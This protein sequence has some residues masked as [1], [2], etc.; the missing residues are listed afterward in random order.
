MKRLVSMVAFLA[1]ITLPVFADPEWVDVGIGSH[2]RKW[3]GGNGT[4]AVA[5]TFGGATVT[6]FWGAKIPGGIEYF[7][8]QPG[9]C[10]FTSLGFCSFFAAPGVITLTVTGGTPIVSATAAGPTQSGGP[11]VV[12]VDS[13]LMFD[14]SVQVNS[15]SDDAEEDNGAISL[16]SD[17]LE[18]MD[19]NEFVGIRFQNITV[20]QGASIILAEIQFDPAEGNST[21]PTL[22]FKAQAIDDAPT[23]T[24]TSGDIGNRATTTGSVVWVPSSDWDFGDPPGPDSL[25]S[26]LSLIIQ[27]VIDR[28]GWSSG[29]SIV[30]IVTGTGGTRAESFDGDPEA[31]V[32]HIVG[33]S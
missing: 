33:T 13:N 6:L 7:Q 11:A 27:E 16:T 26:D 32:L 10:T 31:P 3:T 19:D 18:M 22:T 24:T 30:I 17:H 29:N 5:G 28:L 21:P 2:D 23:F 25:T 15:S 4:F 14:I 1:I 9:N 12:F 8:I 20:P